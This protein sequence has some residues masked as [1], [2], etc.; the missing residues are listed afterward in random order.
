MPIHL[1]LDSDLMM[2]PLMGQIYMF[3]LMFVSQGD[4][5]LV[6]KLH[7]DIYGPSHKESLNPFW[8][9]SISIS[10]NPRSH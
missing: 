10:L 7:Q 1:S 2:T 4:W 6:F 8:F 9:V 5:G 3:L